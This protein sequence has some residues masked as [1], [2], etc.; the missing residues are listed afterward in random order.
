MIGAYPPIFVNA[1][2]PAIKI[3]P[4]P[5]GHR[6]HLRVL[7][8]NCGIRFANDRTNVEI[9]GGGFVLNSTDAP[10]ERHWIGDVWIIGQST[11]PQAAQIAAGIE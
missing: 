4:V 10:I 11:N 9:L 6:L 5:P 8:A 2:G 3:G 7:T 1:A